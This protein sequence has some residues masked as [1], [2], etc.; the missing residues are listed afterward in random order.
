MIRALYSAASGMQAQELAIDTIANNLANVNTNGFK[1]VRVDFQDLIYQTVTTAGTLSGVGTEIPT[2]IQIGHGSRVAAT[3]RLFTQ[4]EFKQTDN[5][6]DLVIEGPGFFQVVNNDGE[7]V[8]TRAGSFKLD[9][10]GRIVTSD[11]LPLEPQII[12]PENAEQITI[13][14]DGLV[15]VK[16]PGIKELQEVGQITLARFANPA[17][18]EAIGQ[19]LFKSTTASGQPQIGTPATDG[20]G[21]LLQGFLETSNVKLVE[22]MVSMIVAQ[23]AYEI[24]SKSIQAA[25]EM[26]NVA[27]N[28]R[29]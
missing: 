15:Q 25:D 26:L 2:G 8:Y 10:Q 1:R 5:E 11:G 4:G 17:G 13:S 3:Q 20:Y 29:R 9:S 21:S 19:N 14:K 16:L 24:S 22:E 7:V 12:V 6:L 27:N 28:L 18:L 23:R